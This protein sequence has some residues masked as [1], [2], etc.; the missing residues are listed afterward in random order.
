MEQHLSR[1]WA[2]NLAEHSAALWRGRGPSL[3]VAVVWGLS[4][5]E[6]RGR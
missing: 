4:S 5:H 3:Q 6:G 1:R 2:K